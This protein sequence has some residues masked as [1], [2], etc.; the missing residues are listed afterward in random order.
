MPV[1]GASES[2]TT[3]T[4]ARRAAS[5]RPASRAS[6]S[7]TAAGASDPEWGGV[8]A[9]ISRWYRSS[10]SS[11]MICPREKS[12]GYQTVP[13]TP[14]VRARSDWVMVRSSREPGSVMPGAE[15]PAQ[16]TANNS[17]DRSGAAAHGGSDRATE[18]ADRA[19]EPRPAEPA[20]GAAQAAHRTTEPTDGAAEPADRTAQAAD[21]AA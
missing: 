9:G 20:D 15:Q 14:G 21:G 1:S 11:A 12:M 18:A 19:A 13:C 2:T 8:P 10:G 16:E 6:R 3:G 17:S 7:S 4:M 5:I